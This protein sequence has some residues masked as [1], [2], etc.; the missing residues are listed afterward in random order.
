MHERHR[1]VGNSPIAHGFSLTCT[2]SRIGKR[3]A[4]DAASDL[5][6]EHDGECQGQKG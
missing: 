1:N 5:L 3:E 4:G 2:G 6:A